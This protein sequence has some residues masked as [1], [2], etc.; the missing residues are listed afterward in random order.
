MTNMMNCRV[1][2]ML[3]SL[4]LLVMIMTLSEHDKA[5]AEGPSETQRDVD[6]KDRF[7]RWQPPSAAERALAVRAL[8]DFLRSAEAKAPK[9][10]RPKEIPVEDQGVPWGP[11][12]EF[13]KLDLE[14]VSYEF[15]PCVIVDA[16]TDRKTGRV[17]MAEVS[18]ADQHF[19]APKYPSCAFHDTRASN[20]RVYAV[21]R[22]VLEVLKG[23]YSNME[24]HSLLDALESGLRRDPKLGISEVPTRGG[25]ATA[26][27][28]REAVPEK[29]LPEQ[30]RDDTPLLLRIDLGG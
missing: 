16:K 24:F 6:C 27:V 3:A 2:V 18:S 10:F 20:R 28:L 11:C 30:F 14:F 7:P 9:D 17:T 12:L 5:S 25:G 29:D 21:F 15:G 23:P 4:I 19:W 22:I 13:A 26:M 8:A 1:G